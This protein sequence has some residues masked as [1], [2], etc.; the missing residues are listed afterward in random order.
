MDKTLV[1]TFDSVHNATENPAVHSRSQETGDRVIGG[2]IPRILLLRNDP[3]GSS[4]LVDQLQQFGCECRIACVREGVALLGEQDFHIVVCELNVSEDYTTRLIS[5]LIGSN[6]SLF[7]HL[8][9]EDSCWWLPAVLIGQD[10]RGTPALRPKD[11]YPVLKELL[12]EI[13]SGAHQSSLQDSVVL[14][15]LVPSVFTARRR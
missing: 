14:A 5:Q 6:A 7:F 12:R 15:E 1:L 13:A 9:V 2:D 11:F 8:D 4:S 10:C 3:A